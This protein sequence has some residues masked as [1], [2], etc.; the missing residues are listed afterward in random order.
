MK[1]GKSSKSVKEGQDNDMAIDGSEPAQDIPPVPTLQH[2][3][4][5]QTL[6]ASPIE[7]PHPDDTVT[8][9]LDGYV[10]MPKFHIPGPSTV[11]AV[12]MSKSP[13]LAPQSEEAEEILQRR[14]K[15]DSPNDFD[16]R[17]PPPTSK[18]QFDTIISLRALHL[19]A[20]PIQGA[21]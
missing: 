8:L 2:K 9:V 7:N 10:D 6:P 3:R 16:L 15:S 18:V 4:S 12:D 14:R 20:A 21:I 19:E 17:V 11:N 13:P 1:R 5:S